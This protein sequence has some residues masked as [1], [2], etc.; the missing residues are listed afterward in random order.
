MAF[1]VEKRIDNIPGSHHPDGVTVA[2]SQRNSLRHGAA[3]TA[4]VI[5]VGW[6]VWGL[7]NTNESIIYRLYGLI[8]MEQ[9]N[10]EFT[11]PSCLLTN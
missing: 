11:K 5:E 2:A 8:Y 4:Q 3:V 7:R 6:A 9:I 10:P 1:C